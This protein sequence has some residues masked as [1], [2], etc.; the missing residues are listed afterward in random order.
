MVNWGAAGERV[1]ALHESSQRALERAQAVERYLAVI[2]R[3]EEYDTAYSVEASTLVC[4]IRSQ[5]PKSQKRTEAVII[6][7]LREAP[8]R[9]HCAGLSV[10]LTF[11]GGLQVVI[12]PKEKGRPEGR[13]MLNE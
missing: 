3:P 8:S 5:A 11:S 13:P 2:Y 6:R 1:E 4:R 10:R 7:A 9:R 12:E